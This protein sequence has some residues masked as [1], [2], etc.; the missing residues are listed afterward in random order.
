MAAAVFFFI[1]R[2]TASRGGYVVVTV[3][4]NKTAVYSLAENRS[5]RIGD[6]QNGNTLVIK[7]GY[8]YIT[9]ATCPDKLCER[10]GKICMG[11]QT[12]VCLPNRTVINIDSVEQSYTDFIQ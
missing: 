12:I 8:A 7:D 2:S 11:N 10:Q 6:T 1:V 9:D 4:G 5:V 3:D